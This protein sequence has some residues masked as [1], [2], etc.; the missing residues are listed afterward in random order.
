MEM[1]LYMK[2]LD[3][4]NCAEKIRAETERIPFVKKADM[5][6]MAKKLS[7]TAADESG[8]AVLREVRRITASMEPDVEVTLLENPASIP[9]GNDDDDSSGVKTMAVRIAVSAA[10]FMGLSISVS[11]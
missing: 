9:A 5:N 7:I 11:L 8:E 10:V 2:N 4:P 6:F 1:V 3:C